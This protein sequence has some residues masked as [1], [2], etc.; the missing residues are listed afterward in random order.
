MDE[1]VYLSE[2]C[3]S[4]CKVNSLA[5]WLVPF[6]MLVFG[7]ETTLRSLQRIRFRPRGKWD[8]PICVLVILIL[9]LITFLLPLVLPSRNRCKGFQ[10]WWA[11]H[12]AEIGLALGGGL[13]LLFLFSA[14]IITIQRRRTV[15]ISNDERIAAIRV[16]YYLVLSMIILVRLGK[17]V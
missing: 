3:F 6:T 13:I 2:E 15:G 11:N 7:I 5:M 10:L 16:V 8:A 9:L 12:Y 4:D 1:Y 17:I 14:T